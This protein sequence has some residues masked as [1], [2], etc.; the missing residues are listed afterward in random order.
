[1]YA[2][3]FRKGSHFWEMNNIMILGRSLRKK[4]KRMMIGGPSR[5]QYFT[6]GVR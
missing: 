3:L 6:P 4:D 5:G 1:M 2:M